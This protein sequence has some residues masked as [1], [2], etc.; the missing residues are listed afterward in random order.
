MTG[1]DSSV[2]ELTPS[3]LVLLITSVEALQE[4]LAGVHIRL[5]NQLLTKKREV[6]KTQDP[7]GQTSTPV[8]FQDFLRSLGVDPDGITAQNH[9]SVTT[10]AITESQ[11]D[12]GRILEDD[13]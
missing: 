2:Q 11:N 8:D 9:G 12:Q 6:Q 4:R 10:D 13:R 3:D 7:F 1:G 5:L